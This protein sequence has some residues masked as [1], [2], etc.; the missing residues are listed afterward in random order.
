VKDI[1]SELLRYR[2]AKCHIWNTY[3]HDLVENLNDDEPLYSFEIIEKRLFSALICHPLGLTFNFDR[4]FGLD[5]VRTIIVKPKPNLI[6]IPA[7]L[8]DASGLNRLWRKAENLLAS[9]L[10]LAFMDFFQWDN[11]DYLSLPFVK[12]E[13][14]DCKERPD[15]QGNEALVETHLVDFV[16]VGDNA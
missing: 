10:S 12:C 1:R 9:G 6:E 2:D 14:M 15:Y 3:F 4:G 16:F 11:Y 8:A 13:V 5:S 7:M